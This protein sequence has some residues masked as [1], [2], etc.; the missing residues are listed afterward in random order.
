MK[1]PFVDLQTQFKGLR[2][3]ILPG[4]E[5]VMEQADFILGDDVEAFERE[6]AAFCGAGECVGVASGCDALLFAIKACG[7][8]PGD[9]IIV[10]A[11]TFIATVLAVTAA[12]ATPVL[13][14]CLDEYWTIDPEEVRRAVTDR[15]G[16]VIPVHLYGQA[17][18]MDSILAIAREH[19]LRVIEDA[20]QAH[21]AEYHDKACG[22]IGD[23]GCFSF[24]PGKNLGAY[25]D[26]GAVVT[27]RADLAEQVRMLRNYGQRE[28][29]DHR[30]AGWNSRLDT[31]Q[32]V[33]LRAKLG[34]L[35]EWNEA[36][37][38]HAALYRERLADLPVALPGEA[39]GNRHVYH[40][41][42]ITCPERDAL[43]AFLKERDI[44]CGIHYPVPVHLQEAY[45]SLGQGRG[46]FPRTENLARQ[47]LSLPM[48]P[49]L[50][51]EQ[52]EYVSDAVCSFF[53]GR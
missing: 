45:A 49:E 35:N 16:A 14:D 31:L 43:S 30:V 12:G 25:G 26:A 20:A 33:V 36:R 19:D 51:P 22:S 13:V 40:L 47:A 17:A 10:P 52:I 29:Y 37:R 8:G 1:V 34:R 3:E 15:T 41:F 28:K 2:G 48:F 11:N 50:T 46:V 24:Y 53:A 4:I 6:F 5:R 27:G 9:E 42:V 7:L 44:A 23:A 38:R 39:P 21:G 32:A 18:D